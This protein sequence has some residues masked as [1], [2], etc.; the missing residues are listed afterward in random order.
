MP[1]SSTHRRFWLMALLSTAAGAIVSAC[2]SAPPQPEPG[3]SEANATPNVVGPVASQAGSARSSAAPN[4]RA[5][6][7][8]GASH[9]YGLHTD[10]IF[11]GRMPPLLY[12]IGVLNV[13][14]NQAGIVTR[15]DWMRAPR[16]APE[17]IAEIERMIKAASPFPAP[18]RIGKV[19]YTD[20]WL[21]HKSGK[22][23]LDTLTE[24]QN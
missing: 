9:L 15:L 20:T 22:F 21:W 18:V 8:S 1:A 6:R 12:A 3:P 14:I 2:K 4:A 11:K 7:Q 13:E 10:R 17:V 24:G 16:H 23:Q 5:Y 19:V